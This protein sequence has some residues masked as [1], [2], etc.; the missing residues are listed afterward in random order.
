MT[1]LKIAIRA[2]LCTVKIF[3]LILGAITA[4]ILIRVPDESWWLPKFMTSPGETMML[5][6]W[7]NMNVVVPLAI[8]ICS[9][10]LLVG[11]WQL[12]VFL[13]STLRSKR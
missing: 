7:L 12:S 13:C 9:G 4:T 10:V 11:L 2:K 6:L 3:T 8:V 1:E 5:F